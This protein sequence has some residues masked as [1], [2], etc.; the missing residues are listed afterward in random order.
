MYSTRSLPPIPIVTS[1]QPNTPAFDVV[2]YM[3]FDNSSVV[4][5][6][7]PVCIKFNLSLLFIIRYKPFSNIPKIKHK[8]RTDPI[9]SVLILLHYQY[10]TLFNEISSKKVPNYYQNY[11]CVLNTSLNQT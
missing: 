9:G 7:D 4:T 11:S 1:K 5:F 2:V 6:L 8:K 3:F 10:N